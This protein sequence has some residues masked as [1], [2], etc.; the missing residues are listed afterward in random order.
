MYQI[1]RLPFQRAVT[2]QVQL[3]NMVPKL[4]ARVGQMSTETNQ[5]EDGFWILVESRF[6]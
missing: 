6:M 1:R 3:G 5:E 4:Y 2:C